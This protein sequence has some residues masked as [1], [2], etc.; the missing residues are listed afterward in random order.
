MNLV[1]VSVPGTQNAL[2]G[3]EALGTEPTPLC[4]TNVRAV[5]AF[6]SP[7]LCGM[8]TVIPTLRREWAKLSDHLHPPAAYK[9]QLAVGE[10]RACH[11]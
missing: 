2:E 8:E 9:I 5:M 11:P 1:C 3:E 7:A 10:K 6:N 4:V